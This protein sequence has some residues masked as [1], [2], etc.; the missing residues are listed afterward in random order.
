MTLLT[1]HFLRTR[2]PIL[3]SISVST[4]SIR[5]ASRS[6]HSTLHELPESVEIFTGE[7]ITDRGSIFIGRACKIESSEQ[8]SLSVGLGRAVY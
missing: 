6:R 8:V 7:S 1:S 4:P 5:L 2:P 3:S